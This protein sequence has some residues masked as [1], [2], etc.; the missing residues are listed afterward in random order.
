MAK[1]TTANPIQEKIERITKELQELGWFDNKIL[2]TTIA[3][4][5]E[6]VKE[7]LARS[8]Y[9]FERATLEKFVSDFETSFLLL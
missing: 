6:R 3:S 8:N 4:R 2:E 9:V 1:K 7:L 5:S